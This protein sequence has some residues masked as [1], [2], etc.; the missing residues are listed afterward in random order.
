MSRSF[1][2]N[3]CV[4]LLAT[5]VAAVAMMPRGV[6]DGHR[7]ELADLIV[8]AM[9]K[10]GAIR[11]QYRVGGGQEITVCYDFGSKA[12]FRTSYV[13]AGSAVS[14]SFAG[15]DVGGRVF[16]GRATKGSGSYSEASGLVHAS[17]LDQFLPTLFLAG[18]LAEPS[19][20][21]SVEPTADGW[22]VTSRLVRGSRIQPAHALPEAVVKSA[23]GIEA[24]MRTVTFF[25]SKDLAIVRIETK[26]SG[27]EDLSRAE[28]SP[29]G[30]QVAK[31]PLHLGNVELIECEWIRSPPSDMF[32]LAAVEDRVVARQIADGPLRTPI[33]SSDPDAPQ[34]EPIRTAPAGFFGS[35]LRTGVLLAGATLIVIALLAWLRRRGTI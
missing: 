31:K 22:A 4:G 35:S 1:P 20:V 12:W 21:Q 25:V 7:Q 6:D 8:Q 5:S 14:T 28:C 16:G 29:T 34:P 10:T 26:G 27:G 19:S 24:L 3:Y 9:P 33:P 15:A 2:L 23:G 17:V 18:V 11:A 30:F 32:T 13:P